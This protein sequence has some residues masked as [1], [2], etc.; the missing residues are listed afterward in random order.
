[1]PTKTS[2]HRD[3]LILTTVGTIAIICLLILFTNA[4]KTAQVPYEG[5][6]ENARLPNLEGRMLRGIQ[7]TP[8]GVPVY[9]EER[10]FAEGIPFRSFSRVVDRIPTIYTACGEDYL[11]AGLRTKKDVESL[12]PNEYCS[13]YDELQVYCCSIPLLKIKDYE[14]ATDENAIH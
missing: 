2:S 10:A 3:V 7:Q 9:D 1:M 12:I 5:P 4:Q 8:E 14:N 11:H 13:F 6:I